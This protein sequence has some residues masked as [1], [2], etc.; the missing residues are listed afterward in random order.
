MQ[1]VIDRVEVVGMLA[2]QLEQS[3]AMN[4]NTVGLPR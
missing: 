4:H 3:V 1:G 2:V